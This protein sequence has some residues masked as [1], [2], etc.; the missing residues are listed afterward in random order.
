MPYKSKAQQRFFHANKSKL[1]SQGVN[2][3]EWDKATA[4]KR[5]PERLGKTKLQG[6]VYKLQQAMK[7]NAKANG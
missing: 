4:N 6:S 1:E 3:N 2:V 7:I 5:L